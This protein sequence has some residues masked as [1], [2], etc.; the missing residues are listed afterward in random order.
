MNQKYQISSESLQVSIQENGAELCSVKDIKTGLEFMWDANP[1]IWN[2]HA[3]VLFPIVGKLNNNEI[4]INGQKYSMNQHGF[5]RD[6]PFEPIE[7]YSDLLKFMLESNEETLKKFPYEFK[8]FITYQIVKNKVSITYSCLNQGQENM[9][10]SVGA[11]PGF[12]LPLPQLDQ[13]QIEFEYPEDLNRHLLKD[14]L[15]S[16]ETESLGRQTQILPLN[17]A[18]FLKDA[19]VL[20]GLKST[21]LKLV[22]TET[23]FAVK[24][25]FAGFPYMGIWAKLGAQDF[26]CLEP[27]QGLADSIGFEGEISQKKGIHCLGPGSELS[28]TYSLEF[29]AG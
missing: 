24:L 20:E 16:G 15:F 6:M 18:L 19:I 25:D 7:V 9:Y 29:S 10:F 28:F 3:P 17:S 12:K 27:W 13:Y 4:R 1:D 14:G 8:F 2:R 21:W 5:A 26:I 11:H 23:N 22:Q